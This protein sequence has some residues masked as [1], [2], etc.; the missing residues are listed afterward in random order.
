MDYFN[1]DDI[2]PF[3]GTTEVDLWGY[4]N[5]GLNNGAMYNGHPDMQSARY[6]MLKKSPIR[7]KATPGSNMNCMI[8]H[9]PL[10]D[11]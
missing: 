7:L 5:E 9:I 2:F 11:G 3:H 6:G 8:A 4:Y 10:P 1:E